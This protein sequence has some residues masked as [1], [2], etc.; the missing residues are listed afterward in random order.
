MTGNDR[1]LENEGSVWHGEVEISG[2]VP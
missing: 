1:S 2:D